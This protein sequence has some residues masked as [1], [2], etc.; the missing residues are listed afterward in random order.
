MRVGGK[1]TI[2]V[3]KGELT[4]MRIRHE[5]T[6]RVEKTYKVNENNTQT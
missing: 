3:I 5:T 1:F 4:R 6:L 2:V